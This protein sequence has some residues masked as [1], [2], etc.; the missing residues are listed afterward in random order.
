MQTRQ[1]ELQ[2]AL[3]E[4]EHA[5]FQLRCA[6]RAEGDPGRD[7]GQ[8]AATRA[9]VGYYRAQ[10]DRWGARVGELRRQL[11]ATQPMTVTAPT[12]REVLR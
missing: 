1:S 4:L 8:Q 2:T 7:P 9:W 5:R 10:V 11:L 3:S 12:I 6:Q